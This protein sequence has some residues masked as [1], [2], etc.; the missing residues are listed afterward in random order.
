MANLA[1]QRQWQGMQPGFY[2]VGQYD[3]ITHGMVLVIIDFASKPVCGYS[4][5]CFQHTSAPA[6]GG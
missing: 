2:F 1:T 4:V 6:H 5:M 3:C